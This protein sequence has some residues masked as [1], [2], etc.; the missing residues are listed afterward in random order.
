MQAVTDNNGDTGARGESMQMFTDQEAGPLTM[1]KVSIKKN[2]ILNPAEIANGSIT[3]SAITEQFTESA[4]LNGL[5][6]LDKL[7]F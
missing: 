6:P 7:R 2:F 3:R 1:S 5:L 4:K